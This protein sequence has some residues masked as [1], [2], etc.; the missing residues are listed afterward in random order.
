MHKPQ[1][2]LHQSP[3]CW[4]ALAPSKACCN[5]LLQVLTMMQQALCVMKGFPYIA[6]KTR[7]LEV[8]AALRGEP[9]T[10]LLAQPTDQDDFEHHTSWQRVVNYLKTVTRDN[11]HWHVP[12]ATEP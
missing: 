5:V 8:L 1:E 4:T 11:V 7:A 10:V 6:D 9:P 3:D 12:F 2:R